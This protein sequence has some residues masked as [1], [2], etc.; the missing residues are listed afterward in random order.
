MQLILLKKTY[1]SSDRTFYI[2]EG[3]TIT[4]NYNETLDSAVIR[5]SHLTSRITDLEPFDKVI[6]RDETHR[7]KDKYMCVDT[8]TETIESLDP[9]IYNYD[10]SLFSE[11]KELENIILPN[12]SITQLKNN[13]RTVSDYLGR[14]LTLYGPKLRTADG[15]IAKYAFDA[16][17]YDFTIFDVECPETQWNAPTLR[18]VLTTLMMV[19]DCIPVVRNNKIGYINLTERKSDISSDSHIN[20]IQ[21][22]QSSEDYVSELKMNMVNVMQTSLDGVKQTVNR[23][24]HMTFRTEDDSYVLTDENYCLKTQFPILRV[25]HL[26]MYFQL[27]NRKGNVIGSINTYKVD[28][29]GILLKNGDVKQVLYEQTEYNALP[30]V[31]YNPS[32]FDTISQ[33]MSIYYTRYSN[34]ISGFTQLSK[35]TWIFDN[36]I[37]TLN[38]LKQLIAEYCNATDG[39]MY[40]STSSTLVTQT[41][42]YFSTFFDIEYETTGDAV[43]QAGKKLAQSHER[44]VN[45]NQTFSFVDSYNQG[46]MEY[47]KANRLGNQQLHINA[48]FTESGFNYLIFSRVA[49]YRDESKDHYSSRNYYGWTDEDGNTIYSIRTNPTIS[50]SL[51]SKN[52]TNYTNIG[53]PSRV[54]NN[55]LVGIGD[56]YEDSV[57]YQC[58]YQIYDNHIEVN[59]IA[60]KD[61]ILRDYFTGVK[62][63]IRAWNYAP[64]GESFTRHDLNKY[65]LEFSLS[66]KTEPVFTDLA[67]SCSYFVSPLYGTYIRPLKYAFV[68]TETYPTT[69][70][71]Y[72]ALDLSGR[73]IGN[74]IV[75]TFGFDD[76][77][78]IAKRVSSELQTSNIRYTELHNPNATPPEQDYLVS[79]RSDFTNKYG[80]IPLEDTRYVDGNGEFATLFYQLTYTMDDEDELQ[81]LVNVDTVDLTSK[82]FLYRICQLPEVDSELFEDYDKIEGHK[83][84]RKDN[85]EVPKLSLQFEFCADTNDILFTKKFL[86]LQ[87]CIRELTEEESQ[88]QEVSFTSEISTS[89]WVNVGGPKT[90]NAIVEPPYV[91]IAGEGVYYKGYEIYNSSLVGATLSSYSIASDVTGYNNTVTFDNNYTYTDPV[92][93]QSVTTA[94][95]YG[96]IYTT[97]GSA[98]K[99]ATI[100]YQQ[101]TGEGQYWTYSN[102]Y[103]YANLVGQR[104]ENISVSGFTPGVNDTVNCS[105]NS[106]TGTFNLYIK[107]YSQPLSAMNITI[108]YDLIL[109]DG[110]Y[111]AN[112][113]KIYRG[114]ASNYDWRNPSISNATELSGSSLSLTNYGDLSVKIAI[115]GTSDDEDYAYYITDSDDNILLAVKGASTFYLNQLFT[116]DYNI[117]DSD[118]ELVD[119]I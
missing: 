27:L 99:T 13:K 20:Y 117:Y 14:Y 37:S 96:T 90:V 116:R 93:H 72:F 26:W 87:E 15:F 47:Q 61:Y 85:K 84:I 36:K 104:V 75:F 108:T 105:F 65:Y 81:N 113:Y 28:L 89:D 8:Y 94:R 7:L 60:T 48:R 18:E 114:S 62:A 30:L 59:A 11:T 100:T 17:N 2:D 80:G 109:Q 66:R 45:D 41:N 19:V 101:D 107:T 1:D 69:Q 83:I 25:K 74:S 73:I 68:R 29:C 98:S 16:T 32:N 54:Y 50:T 78:N 119:K 77:F 82:S 58:Q 40:E 55:H 5:I 57:V 71:N 115:S 39:E 9:Y 10:I 35:Q 53:S 111:V 51:Y 88:S 64:A 86:Q 43:F 79:I 12:L 92:T 23:I 4:E 112:T 67:A 6:L 3:S 76:N 33:N 63:R 22:S 42:V 56:C 38:V 46:F 44:V 49:Y 102:T 91:A 103:Y 110:T 95:F 118:G 106:A 31:R 97:S 34:I 70:D 21:R 52:G 24:E